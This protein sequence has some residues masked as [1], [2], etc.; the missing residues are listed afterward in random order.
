MNP[1]IEECFGSLENCQAVQL[2]SYSG[3]YFLCQGTKVVYVGK[4]P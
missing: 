1:E 3:V 2:H 4:N